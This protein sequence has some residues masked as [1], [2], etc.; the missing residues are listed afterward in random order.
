[1]FWELVSELSASVSAAGAA[2]EDSLIAGLST[3]GT[4][5]QLEPQMMQASSS[6]QIT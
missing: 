4:G 1:M 5:G 6:V 2:A 3:G